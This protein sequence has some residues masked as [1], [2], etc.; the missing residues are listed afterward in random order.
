MEEKKQEGFSEPGRRT[1]A[2]VIR[3]LP[4]DFQQWVEAAR[5]YDL[6][7]V[8]TKTSHYKLRV[9]EEMV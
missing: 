5:T 8:Y 2:V 4:P 1:Y 6:M 7:V 9:V 3:G